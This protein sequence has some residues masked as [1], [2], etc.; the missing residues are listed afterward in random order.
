[1]PQIAL[2]RLGKTFP[3]GK[4]GEV[5]A[6]HD[7]T[8]AIEAGELLV[9][10]GPSGSGKT[11]LLRLIAGLE[12]PS[13]GRILFNGRDMA[14]VPPERR[15]VGMVFQRGALFP[16]LSAAENLALGLRLQRLPPRQIQARVGE[17]AARL[18]IEALLGRLPGALSAGERQRVA[19]GRALATR[20]AVLLLDE[21]L[22]ALD[23]PLRSQ[24]RRE[25]ARLRGADG[26]TI[27]HVTHDQD[28]ALSLGMRVAVMR[29]GVL[30]Q[31]GPPQRLLDEP[32]N[33]FVAGFMGSPPLNLLT[34]RLVREE[35]GL[36]LVVGGGE[37]GGFK[38]KLPAEA[39][40]R[41]AREAD[42]A[43]TLGL[44]IEDVRIVPDDSVAAGP[45]FRAEVECLEMAGRRR[46]AS[47]K[48]GPQ[49]LLA[50]AGAAGGLE[51]GQRRLAM[52]CLER[53]CWFDT[54]TGRRLWP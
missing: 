23:A 32:E 5:V 1:M 2:E 6:L 9:V 11:T 30:L 40:G 27:I 35:G 54:A 39:A 24:L 26:L 44:R 33:A 22:T 12:R 52:V 49:R 41:F 3:D 28:E 45:M 29:Q 16:H 51:P 8:L 17:V 36:V 18:G 47:L 37:A 10:V 42:G 20:P 48:C 50:E 53:A 25:I 43:V 31:V 19:L 13:D 38:V 15:G 34:G 46:L 7:F 21:P 14:A 4:E